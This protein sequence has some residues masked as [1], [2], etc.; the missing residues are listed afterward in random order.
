M[1]CDYTH[2]MINTTLEVTLN[3]GHAGG[4]ETVKILDEHVASDG[5]G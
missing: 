2:A 5:E 4:R 1:Q 3:T